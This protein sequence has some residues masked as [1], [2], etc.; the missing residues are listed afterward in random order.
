MTPLTG[1]SYRS[2]NAGTKCAERVEVTLKSTGR[3]GQ[4]DIDV[5]LAS[6][7]VSPLRLSSSSYVTLRVREPGRLRVLG[8]PTASKSEPVV[9]T[10]LD[11][12]MGRD[13]LIVR[14]RGSADAV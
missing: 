13:L 10:L 12:T 3:N 2:A 4:Y 11:P 6:G 8:R 14:S 1:G 9:E 7:G 5:K